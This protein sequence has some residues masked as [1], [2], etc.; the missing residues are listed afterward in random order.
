MRKKERL[1]GV[2]RINTRQLTESSKRKPSSLRHPCSPSGTASSTLYAS[3]RSNVIRGGVLRVSR[4]R[5][6]IWGRKRYLG[7]GC[8]FMKVVKVSEVASNKQAS[9]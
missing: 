8:T 6:G 2:N 1:L 3:G 5:V 7:D 9:C 4:G